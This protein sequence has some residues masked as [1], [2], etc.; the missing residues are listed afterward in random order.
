MERFKNAIFKQREEVNSKMAEMFELLKELT[1]SQAS[2]KV[3]VREEARHLITKHV[4]SIS[5]NR[6]EEEKSVR[7]NEVVSESVVEPD[8]SDIAEPLEEVD[9]MNE[10]KNRTD[11]EPVRSAEEKLTINEEEEL[12]GVSSSRPVGYYL[13][14]RINE[15]LIES[16]VGNQ[17]FNDSLLATQVGGLKHMDALVDPLGIAKDVLIEV[18]GYVYLI[19]FVILDINE[20][21]NRPFI[22]GTPFLTTAKAVIKC[23]KGTITLRSRKNKISFHKR[24]EPL[25]GV[26]RENKNN[27]EPISPTTTINKLVLE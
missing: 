15:K 19:D 23:D 16:L 25:R 20:D 5:L 18:T 27:I 12:V 26:E 24:P 9:K 17:R 13:K 4:N 7:N 1:V 21:E 2:R 8:K 11:D 3:L 22:L 6:I 14:H 10:A